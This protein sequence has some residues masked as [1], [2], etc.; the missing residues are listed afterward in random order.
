MKI[1]RAPHR[2]ALSP[3]EAIAVQRRMA[4]QVVKM[5]F[6]RNGKALV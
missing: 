1:P 6:V 4:A 2:F 5:P 3:A